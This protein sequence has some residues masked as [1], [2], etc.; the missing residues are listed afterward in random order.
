MQMA[1]GVNTEWFDLQVKFG[2]YLPKEKEATL[3]EIQ[4]KAQKEHEEA[5]KLENQLDKKDM[6]GLNDM[7]DDLDFDDEFMREY[8][9][10]RRNELEVK[11]KNYK[12]GEVKE[13]SRNE[14]VREVT[15]ADPE[16]FVVLHLYQN[17]NE[18]C[19]L[20]NE[21]LPALARSNGHVPHLLF[22]SSSSRSS[23]TSASRTSPT[24]AA[25]ASSSTRPASPSPTSPTS[26]S[27]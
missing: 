20:I 4:L 26:T 25:P 22:R 2:N 1:N 8:M 27:T 6:E 11:A 7:E 5:N 21:R 10:K 3:A 14:Y 24:P 9:A 19:G 13:I 18:F 16:S 12:Y 17:S 23:P 15:E